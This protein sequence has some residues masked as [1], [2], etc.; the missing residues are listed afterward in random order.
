MNSTQLNSR[1]HILSWE[2][3]KWPLYAKLGVF[4]PRVMLVQC[5]QDVMWWCKRILRLPEES[6]GKRWSVPEEDV[7]CRPSCQWSSCKVQVCNRGHTSWRN[8]PHKEDLT[9]SRDVSCGRESVR[10][11]LIWR[12]TL[13]QLDVGSMEARGTTHLSVGKS[14]GGIVWVGVSGWD[15][16]FRELPDWSPHHCTLLF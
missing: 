2:P 5:T 4:P 14:V 10:S 7:Q 13:Y 3:P 1:V 6:L 12:W 11:E 15:G 16:Q 9:T 8:L